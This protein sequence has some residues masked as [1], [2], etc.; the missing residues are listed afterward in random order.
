MEHVVDQLRPPV[1]GG[2]GGAP[3][4]GGFI[5]AVA[6]ACADSQYLASGDREIGSWKPGMSENRHDWIEVCGSGSGFCST[7][8]APCPGEPPGGTTAIVR[9]SAGVRMVASIPYSPFRFAGSV[10]TNA[11]AR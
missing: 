11:S 1:G 4:P 10:P 2:R 8:T 6:N 3:P 9:P 5:P 7:G